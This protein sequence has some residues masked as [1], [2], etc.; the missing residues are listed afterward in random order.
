MQ[1]PPHQ[2]GK[3]FWDRFVAVPEK[4]KEKKPASLK[5]RPAWLRQDCLGTS[6]VV[7][8]AW[9]AAMQALRRLTAT[10]SSR[11]PT[12]MVKEQGPQRRTV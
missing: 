8:K 12:R 3:W 1:K 5:T 2:V 10:T 6:P 7:C 4:K 11:N 9:S